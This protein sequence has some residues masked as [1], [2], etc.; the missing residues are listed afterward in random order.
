VTAFLKARRLAHLRCRARAGA[1]II[2]SGP[3]KDPLPHIRLK[4]LTGTAWSVEEFSHTGR[5]SPLPIQAPLPDAL[6][7]VVADFSWLLDA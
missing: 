7:A 3:K 2:E 4:K 1:I 6:A 5:W